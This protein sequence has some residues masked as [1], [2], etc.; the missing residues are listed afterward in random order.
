MTDTST[1]A[2]YRQIAADMR[3]G[4]VAGQY[5]A[6]RPLPSEQ[7]LAEEYGV[8]RPTVRAAVAELRAAGLV[9]VRAGRGMFVRDTAARP[10]G[11]RVRAVRRGTDGRHV[12]PDGLSW[13]DV[14]EAREESRPA[15]GPLA[16][17][18]GVP[19]ETWVRTRTAVQAAGEGLR[20]IHRVHVPESV[21]DGAGWGVLPAGAGLLQALADLGQRTEVHERVRVAMPL[22]AEVEALGMR[23]GVPLLVATRLICGSTTR[24]RLAVEETRLAG[25]Q[26]EAAYRL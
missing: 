4:I 21:A 1:P 8:S 7:A 19:P 5:L 2:R 23:E 26:W 18:L 9:E 17:L 24:P 20:Q 6:G 14:G 15:A 12:E 25:D 3:D 10:V 11:M 13:A 16:A 22:P